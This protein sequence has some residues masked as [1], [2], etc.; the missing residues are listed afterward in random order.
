MNSVAI[1][2]PAMGNPSW[3][4][5]R[6]MVSLELP[7]TYQFFTDH[8]YVGVDVKRNIMTKAILAEGFEWVLYLDQDARIHPQTLMRLMSWGKPVV[9]ALSFMRSVPVMPSHFANVTDRTELYFLLGDIRLWLKAYQELTAPHGPGIIN[10]EP[11]KSAGIGLNGAPDGSLLTVDYIGAHCL[12]VHRQVL[13][14]IDKVSPGTWFLFDEKGHGED[15]YFATLARQCGFDVHVD[16]S[17]VAGHEW[18]AW[19]I[20]ALE[21]TAFDNMTDWIGQV[22]YHGRIPSR[23]MHEYES[24]TIAPLD[25]DRYQYPQT[26]KEWF[27]FLMKGGLSEEEAM[28]E[29]TFRVENPK[30]T[31]E[32]EKGESK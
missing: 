21:F 5:L 8:T 4:F 20:G 12:L 27:R 32:S 1:C 11:S 18:G 6:S 26:K 16:R 14:A 30:E 19:P 15:V 13:W 9:S 24:V 22:V 7:K 17:V 28:K 25:H 10:R 23:G 31:L 3:P 2:T 29:A